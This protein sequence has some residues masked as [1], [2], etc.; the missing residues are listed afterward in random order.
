MYLHLLYFAVLLLN[1]NPTTASC[2]CQL[3]RNE[4][5]NNN[6]EDNNKYTA[7]SNEGFLNKNGDNTLNL[8]NM[9]LIKKSTF[10]MG[11]N[12]PVFEVDGE[13]P[14]RNITLNSFYLD[15]Y[16]VS[17][18][19]FET[20]IKNTGYVTEAEKFGDSFVFDL[21]LPAE[22]LEGYKDVRA[23][24]APWWVKVPGVSWR[25]PDGIDS[26][27]NGKLNHPVVH[28]SWNDAKNYCEYYGKRLPSE[29][30][31][32]KGCRGGLK[33]KLYPWGNKL[34]PKEKHWANIWQGTF[35][36]NNTIDD[37]YLSTAP[38]NSFPPNNYGL[39]N[40]AG[41]VWEWTSDSWSESPTLRVKKG[42]SYLCH[43]SYCWRYRCAAR[44]HNTADSSAGNLGFRC[45]KDASP[46]D[47]Q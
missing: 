17:N 20:F 12:E 38:V 26:N 5:C 30:E 45:A 43:K 25:T 4:Q 3:N 39:Y 29:A 18:Q 33:Q 10:I 32:E 9:V 24:Q 15:K 28:V 27:L 47:D 1:Y 21:L 44:S 6:F 13:G 7:E 40:M 2:G 22:D 37:G 16:E 8:D 42:G 35:P 14:A 46:N 11:T 34:N 41:N 31:W 36:K 23:V 19:D